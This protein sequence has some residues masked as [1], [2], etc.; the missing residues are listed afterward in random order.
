MPNPVGPDGRSFLDDLWNE[1]PFSTHQE[2][3]ANVERIAGDWVTGGGFSENQRNAIMDAA[4]LAEEAL[5]V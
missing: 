2:F 1:A 5:Q 4:R 3:L